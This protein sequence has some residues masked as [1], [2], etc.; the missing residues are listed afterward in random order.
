[1]TKQELERI[2]LLAAKSRTAA[3]LTA[4]EKTEQASL[5]KR[6]I[7]EVK[8]SLRTQLD[9]ADVLNPDGSVTPLTRKAAQP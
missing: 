7:G 1:M 3:G 5:R 9:H 8:A 6:Y 4:E 2:N